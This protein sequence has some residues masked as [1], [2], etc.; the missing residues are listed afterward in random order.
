[1]SGELCLFGK[2]LE[3][4]ASPEKVKRTLPI[5]QKS[6]IW[7]NFLGNFLVEFDQKQWG[8]FIFLLYKCHNKKVCLFNLADHNFPL[9]GK[10]LETFHY[11]A[12]V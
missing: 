11:L 4:F 8:L 3:I 7:V 9:F 6:P 1:M 5:Q 12:K 2:S 10:S